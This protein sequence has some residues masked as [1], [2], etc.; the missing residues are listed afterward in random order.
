[1]NQISQMPLSDQ[2]QILQ[3]SKDN[4]SFALKEGF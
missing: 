3:I 4:K 2:Q 1:M